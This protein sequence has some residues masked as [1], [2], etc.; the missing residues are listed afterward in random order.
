MSRPGGTE[1]LEPL[2]ALQE[3]LT[4]AHLAFFILQ[5]TSDGHAN[6]CASSEL[7]VNY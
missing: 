5:Q 7:F 3:P 4:A 6:V 2:G 1:G